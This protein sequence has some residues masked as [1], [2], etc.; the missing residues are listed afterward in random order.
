MI[1]PLEFGK[2][3]IR[4]FLHGGLS[5]ALIKL[6]VA[7]APNLYT[8]GEKVILGFLVFTYLRFNHII[9]TGENI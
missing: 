6:L 2:E 9:K 3:D 7:F 4:F 8:D 1:K 5:I